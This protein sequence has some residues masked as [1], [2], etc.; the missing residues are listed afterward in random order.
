MV[1]DVFSGLPERG[2][3]SA[4]L[5]HS[6]LNVLHPSKYPVVYDWRLLWCAKHKPSG[7]HQES[8]QQDEPVSA[9]HVAVKSPQCIMSRGSGNQLTQAVHAVDHF[10]SSGVLVLREAGERL[11]RK[12]KEPADQEDVSELSHAIEFVVVFG[13]L[14][15]APAPALR[16]EN[17]SSNAIA[18]TLMG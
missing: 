11:P 4:D 2:K 7:K 15:G 6:R 17:I 3:V 9:F 14:A 8:W 16:P 10:G 1:T 13:V 12:P 18:A 5:V